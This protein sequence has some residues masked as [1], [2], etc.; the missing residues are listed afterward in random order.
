MGKL[1]EIATVIAATMMAQQSTA[2]GNNLQDTESIP[3][4]NRYATPGAFG[5][6]FYMPS[7]FNS[8]PIYFPKKHTKESYRSQQRARVKRNKARGKKK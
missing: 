8:S 6:T 7:S 5:D 3:I 1:K 4:T 2:K